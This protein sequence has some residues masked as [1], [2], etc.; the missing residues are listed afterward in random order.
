MADTATNAKHA[1]IH[2]HSS[3]HLGPLR[4][5][6]YITDHRRHKLFE[7]SFCALTIHRGTPCKAYG[8]HHYLYMWQNVWTRTS[9]V[10]II[11]SSCLPSSLTLQIILVTLLTPEYVLERISVTLL[12]GRVPSVKLCLCAS[13]CSV[14]SLSRSS[15]GLSRQLQRK[16]LYPTLGALLLSHPCLV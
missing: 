10:I 2:R 9:Y 4:S 12:G 3:V 5:G 1:F 11:V 15:S 14:V 8:E 7:L 16:P 13:R 6:I